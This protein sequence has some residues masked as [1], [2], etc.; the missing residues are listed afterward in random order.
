MFKV[1]KMSNNQH[2]FKF[3]FR[4]QPLACLFPVMAERLYDGCLIAVGWK[5][6]VQSMPSRADP[7]NIFL[8]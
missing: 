1:P 3:N 8:A 7:I 5:Y 2:R 4:L 6:R